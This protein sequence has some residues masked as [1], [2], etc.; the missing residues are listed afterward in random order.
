MNFFY[1]YNI[2]DYVKLHNKVYPLQSKS[3]HNIF[4]SALKRIEKVYG[5]KLEELDLEFLKDPISFHDKFKK[6]QYKDNTFFQTCSCCIKILKMIDAPLILINRYTKYHKQ[7]SDKT[8]LELISAFQVDNL[9]IKYSEI[10]TALED[11]IIVDLEEHN[12]DLLYNDFLNLLITSLFVFN[13]PTRSSNYINMKVY[14][15]TTIP[16]DTSHNYLINDKK[17]KNYTF[18]FNNSR[19]GFLLPQRILPV[20][21]KNLKKLI[22]IYF[23]K[24]YFD[25]SQRW[26]L[27]T[28]SSVHP[29]LKNLE[30][31]KGFM[32]GTETLFGFKITLDEIRKIY[33]K[34]IFE[35]DL[36][37]VEH[38]DLINILGYKNIPK[39]LEKNKNIL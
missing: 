9:K 23:Q 12:N 18:V 13:I 37:L 11:F 28:E 16:E 4:K 36:D 22:D 17:N 25:N 19:Q 7:Q 21:N 26:F 24:Y 14:T 29:E 2:D 34:H 38:F 8:Q 39:L 27:K 3:S 31:Q 15:G 30:I 5:L 1:K 6:T 33:L 32:N 20:V 10:K 35:M